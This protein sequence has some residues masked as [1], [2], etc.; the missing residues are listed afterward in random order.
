MSGKIRSEGGLDHIEGEPI[1]NAEEEPED[2]RE[3]RKLRH[4]EIKKM[5]NALGL[6]TKTKDW[7]REQLIDYLQECE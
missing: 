7:T 5:A 4:E 1:S 3:K 6:N 2:K